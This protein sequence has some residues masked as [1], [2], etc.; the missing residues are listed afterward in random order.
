M[1]FLG[2]GWGKL[3][4]FSER[5]GQFADPIHL[6]SGP[7]FTLVVF[8]EGIC[9]VLVA[10]GLL[11]RWA[12]IPLVIFFVVAG[13]IQHADDPWSRKELA[14]LFLVAFLPL[15]FTGPGRY[16]LDALIAKKKSGPAASPPA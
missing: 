9:T 15:L 5:A 2:H 3:T 14:F 12:V 7:S 13:F 1:L 8:A 10:F 16:S 4:H 11:T 6:G